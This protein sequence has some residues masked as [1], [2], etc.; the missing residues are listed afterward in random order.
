MAVAQI[1][2][3]VYFPDVQERLTRFVREPFNLHRSSEEVANLATV[4]LR[5]H[6]HT[7]WVMIIRG[8]YKP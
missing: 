4:H 6:I 1:N 2:R 7:A 3:K 8:T 5:E